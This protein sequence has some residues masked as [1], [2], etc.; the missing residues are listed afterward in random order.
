MRVY[1]LMC[2]YVLMCVYVLVCVYVLTC[3]IV[4]VYV[5]MY[6][7]VCVSI[8]SQSPSR[9][10][11]SLVAILETPLGQLFGL[12]KTRALSK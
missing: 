7:I 8:F 2:F 1:E 4:C 11:P 6:V 12:N 10:V 3:V 5:L 9:Q